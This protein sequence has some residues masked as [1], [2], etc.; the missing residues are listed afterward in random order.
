M[1]GLKHFAIF[2]AYGSGVEKA[3]GSNVENIGLN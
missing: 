2:S 3:R 1:L